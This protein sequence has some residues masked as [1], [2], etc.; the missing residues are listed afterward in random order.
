[1]GPRRVR[2]RWY[3]G[4]MHGGT[5]LA[6]ALGLTAACFASPPTALPCG[7]N[8]ACPAGLVCQAGMCAPAT[9]P[10]A[11]AA[12]VD[13]DGVD[14][15]RDNCPGVSNAD[16]HDEDGDRAGDTCDPCPFLDPS[17]IGA[18]D[19]DGDADGLPDY[20]DPRPADEGDRLLLFLPM[21]QGDPS[22]RL[23]ADA[24]LEGDRLVVARGDG[25][26]VRIVTPTREDLVIVAGDLLEI[27]SSDA[28]Q[29]VTLSTSVRGND[30]AYCEVYRPPG[31]ATATG[32]KITQLMSGAYSTFASTPTAF[33][34][35]PFAAV[36]E[37]SVEAQKV[38]CHHTAG[39]GA[40]AP[41]VSAEVRLEVGAEL[42]LGVQGVGLAV[43]YL[44]Q[45]SR[46]P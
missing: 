34:L 46:G 44:A 19:L 30:R 1:M 21:H 5:L 8:L 12:D 17:T 3:D 35:G 29:Q 28:P 9:G 16:Q 13:G 39:G 2:P 15:A 36:L 14:D 22:L 24:V 20:C 42:R 45:F 41:T 18:S 27:G 23:G 4:R 7:P 11:A 33:T 26:I 37:A 40:P 6:G 43:D 10:D 25:A 32:L 31:P 38:A